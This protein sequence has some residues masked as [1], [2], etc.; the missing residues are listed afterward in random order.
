[1][2]ERSEFGA[3]GEDFAALWLQARGWRIVDRNVRYRDGELDIVATRAG[4]L[5]FVEV[6]T[7]RS[8][9]YGPPAEAVTKRKRAKI[10]SLAAR[11]LTE[12]R[13]GVAA[14][15]FDVLDLEYDH[16]GFKVTHLEGCF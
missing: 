1:M 11:Y 14:V 10:R 16:R 3:R 4:I 12:R 13:P 9:Q 5:A 15:R 7:R 6:K 8:T 2:H